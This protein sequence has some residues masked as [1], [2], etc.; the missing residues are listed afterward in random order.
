MNN[1]LKNYKLIGL[2]WRSPPQGIIYRP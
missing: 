1:T 2:H